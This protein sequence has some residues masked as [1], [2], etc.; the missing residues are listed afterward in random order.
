MPRRCNYLVPHPPDAEGVAVV[1]HRSRIE[2]PVVIV[3]V[4]TFSAHRK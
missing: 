3:E 4:N 2:D 1:H